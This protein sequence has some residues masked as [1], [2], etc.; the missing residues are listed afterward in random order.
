MMRFSSPR[1]SDVIRLILFASV[2]EE[3]GMVSGLGDLRLNENDFIT[4]ILV[5]NNVRNLFLR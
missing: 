5:S 2:S 1:F 3:G 4:M